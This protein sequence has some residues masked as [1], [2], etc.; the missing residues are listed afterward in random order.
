M[1][2]FL[3]KNVL[4]M[5]AALDQHN[6]E[7]PVPATAILLNPADHEKL[8]LAIPVLWGL[9]VRPDERVRR[10][11]FRIECEGSAWKVEDELLAYIQVPGPVPVVVPATAVESTLE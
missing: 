7:C 9:S 5:R 2:T 8:A 4:V 1:N 3:G 6:G 10:G 11:Y